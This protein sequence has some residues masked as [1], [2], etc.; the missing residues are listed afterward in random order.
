MT[1]YKKKQIDVDDLI[2]L[3]I[4]QEVPPLY[5][6]REIDGIIVK[7]YPFI[8]GHSKIYKQDLPE[9]DINQKD[10]SLLAAYKNELENQLQLN[11]KN[12][13]GRY[14]MIRMK[15]SRW[16]NGKFQLMT[17]NNEE[18][19]ALSM[20]ASTVDTM[21]YWTMLGSEI[22]MIIVDLKGDIYTPK[23]EIQD[24]VFDIDE[25]IK[26]IEKPLQ[27]IE[28]VVSNSVDLYFEYVN[29]HSRLYEFDADEFMKGLSTEYGIHQS[30]EEW[31][32]KTW[33]KVRKEK[34]SDRQADLEVQK[35]YKEKYNGVEI[36]TS[37]IQ[38]YTGRQK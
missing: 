10:Y 31:V 15:I 9:K 22:E 4:E 13:V 23:I 6:T 5:N 32:N 30:K 26:E 8:R 27:K 38:R 1:D 33:D 35:L 34:K 2:Q 21:L 36:S 17:V 11:R 19:K 18:D 14:N 24:T 12:C 28:R 3:A 16:F 29:I 37:T 25:L 7:T 20:F